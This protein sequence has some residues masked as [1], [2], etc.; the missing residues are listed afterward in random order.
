MVLQLD[1][2]A[3]ILPGDLAA[4]TDK[5]LNLFDGYIYIDRCVI[6]GII[7]AI[8]KLNEK[9]FVPHRVYLTVRALF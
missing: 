5:A 7:V 4:K 9:F 2:D 3:V 6:V 8:A 1:L